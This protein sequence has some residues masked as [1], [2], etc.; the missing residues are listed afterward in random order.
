MDKACL[1]PYNVTSPDF[2]G[3]S[4]T[5][6]V[7]NTKTRQV[8][9]ITAASAP[10]SPP[11]ADS[12]VLYEILTKDCSIRWYDCPT[13]LGRTYTLVISPCEVYITSFE[14]GFSAQGTC[15]A[16]QHGGNS[17]CFGKI[18]SD[19][20]TFDT[21]SCSSSF[22]FDN[23]RFIVEGCPSDTFGLFDCSGC[24]PMEFATFEW[25]S[26]SPGEQNLPT[27]PPEAESATEED[28]NE[29]EQTSS[30]I[31]VDN[32]EDDEQQVIWDSGPSTET[33]VDTVCSSTSEIDAP[34]GC[35]SRDNP[36]IAT[37]PSGHAVIAYEDR[38]DNGST[39]IKLALVDTSVEHRIYYYRSLSR[40]TLLKRDSTAEGTEIFEIFDDVLIETTA[41]V[42]QDSLKLG[43]LTGPLAGGFLFDITTAKRQEAADGRYKWVFTFSTGSRS[44]QFAD[45][46]DA[47][48]V[49]FVIT[50]G[51][52]SD[53]SIGTLFELPAHF[54]SNNAQ[55]PV[56]HPS[57][58]AAEN[59]HMIDSSQN[60]YVAYQAFIDEDWRIFVRHVRITE[61][62]SAAPA[63]LAPYTFAAPSS[64]LLALVSTDV[65]NVVYRAVDLQTDGTSRCVLF[66]V[67]LAEDNRQVYNCTEE[68]GQYQHT[69]G[70]EAEKLI[71]FLVVLN[72]L[73]LDKSL[74]DRGTLLEHQPS[75]QIQRAYKTSVSILYQLTIGVLEI[76][77]VSN[78]F[79]L[80]TPIA[81][82]RIPIFL[83][84]N[85]IRQ[86]CGLSKLA[87]IGLPESNTICRPMSSM[88][89]QVC[90][91][92]K[93]TLLATILLS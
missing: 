24:W 45:S 14:N 7:D 25:N 64:S 79:C 37:L 90:P 73:H 11:T 10:P 74:Q 85:I 41:D 35:E 68:V 16:V 72:G 49:S 2:P 69:C 60:L 36:T 21:N 52:L 78:T 84:C 56:A 34:G 12:V 82:P 88:G 70:L 9:T 48:N 93:G 23:H 75:H 61:R 8:A 50:T 76:Q 55:V 27:A 80:T 32:P 29:N 67:F 71:H 51:S 3:E 6:F 19:T 39:T 17:F 92:L 26:D 57:V 59:A 1:G 77:L 58:A 54:D 83:M 13:T 15:D 18:Y 40:G 91:F 20:E 86:I 63:Y 47:H 28:V 46:N 42:P 4:S 43:F 44:P 65:N 5:T 62:D 38:A 33:G 87:M 30:F 89:Q 22:S 53:P 31:P 81:H 66:E